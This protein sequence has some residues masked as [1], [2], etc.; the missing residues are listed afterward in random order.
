MTPFHLG[1]KELKALS[2]FRYQLLH[3]RGFTGREWTPGGD[4]AERLQTQR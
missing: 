2:H 1:K 4:L 3:I